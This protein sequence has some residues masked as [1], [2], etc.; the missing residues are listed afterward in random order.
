MRRFRVV[1]SLAALVVL[2]WAIGW[3]G[4]LERAGPARADLIL[5]GAIPATLYLPDR[6]A[7][8]LGPLAEPPPPELRPA[9]VV[10]AH[11]FAE[12]RLAMS[13]LARAMSR[14]GYAVLTLDFRGHGAN[15]NP[16]S[17]ERGRADFLYSDLAAAVDF[18]RSS[19]D[20]D[21]SRIVVMGHSMGASA[22]LTYATRDTGIDG[23]V[24]ISG[25]W[26]LTG[27]QRPPNALFIYGEADPPELRRSW[28][29][30]AAH[31]AGRARA[32]PGIVY[33]EFDE[34]RAV[35]HVEVAG[36]DH[37]S[38]L[39][40]TSAARQIINWLDRIYGVERRTF[41]VP[42]D[43]RLRPAVLGLLALV[44][45]LP[46]LGEVVGRLAPRLEERPGRGLAGNLMWLVLALTATLPLLAVGSS[47]SLVS[48]EI[49]D[50]AILHLLLSGG[51]LLVGFALA[52]RFRAS[53][54][55]QGWPA[56]V[57][58]AVA[59]CAAVY[60]LLAPIGSV[61]HRLSLTPERAALAL[62]AALLLLPF[63]LAFHFLLRRGG[64]ALSTAV[65]SLGRLA[66]LAAFAA[67]VK[68]GIAPFVVLLMLPLLA[69]LFFLFEVLG[70]SIYATSRN[71]KAAALFEALWLAW[72]FA[73]V[74]PVRV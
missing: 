57:W 31:L 43:R 35:S 60:F 28:R 65:S 37:I 30:L 23:V 15:R 18:L 67:S 22:S 56:T 64:V 20:V 59:G 26:R 10:L 36:A 17:L 68:L 3:L 63:A 52:G 51:V 39:Y 19:P 73:A 29:R 34:A 33:G 48:L 27:P 66:V 38:I 42:A 44:L 54:L 72:I 14:A 70:A 46:G 13:S 74:L 11:G 16:F 40:S 58:A 62:F 9:A 55:L 1:L 50:L 47:G 12:D 8:A 21:G 69:L 32:E 7:S 41:F 49:A 71:W 4:W 24:S 6:G 5:E 25:G 45:L 53:E 61:M 2:L